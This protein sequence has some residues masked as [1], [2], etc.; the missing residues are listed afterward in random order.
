MHAPRCVIALLPVALSIPS[1]GG[2][3]K[4]TSTTI[5]RTL[6]DGTRNDRSWSRTW[7]DR[8]KFK[9]VAS[10]SGSCEIV[11]FTSDCPGAACTTRVVKELSLPVGKSMQLGGLPRGFRHCIAHDAKPVVPACLK[12]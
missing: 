2:C 7:K 5:V 6:E 4:L 9:C 1:L 8:V 11:V 12:A 3:D 10:T